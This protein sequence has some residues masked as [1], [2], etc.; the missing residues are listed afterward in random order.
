MRFAAWILLGV[1]LLLAGCNTTPYD[2]A[3]VYYDRAQYPSDLVK[4]FPGI[5]DPIVQHGR[6][7]VVMTT[8]N[9]N[10]GAYYFCTFAL[11]AN[12]LYVMGWN[13]KTMK[14]ESLA[15]VKL[16]ALKKISIWSFFRA[17]QVQLTESQRLLGFSVTIDDGGYDDGAATERLFDTLKGKGITVVESEGQIKPPPA[18]AP[19]F[20]PIIIPK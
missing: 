6:C 7:A 13:G 8:P 19:M 16:S 10:T 11:T 12:D 9:S 1:A 14:Y 18:P 17:R 15:N 3:T 4:D 2:R 20:I 5:T